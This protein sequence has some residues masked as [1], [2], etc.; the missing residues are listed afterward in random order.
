MINWVESYALKVGFLAVDRPK[1]NF[2]QSNWPF[3]YPFILKTPAR[4]MIYCSPKSPGRAKGS[5]CTWNLDYRV[6]DSVY[7]FLPKNSNLMHS[8]EIQPK[9]IMLDGRFEVTMMNQLTSSEMSFIKNQVLSRIGM[10]NLIIHLET[11]FP[12]R[13]YQ[14]ELIR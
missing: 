11:Q 5:K 12:S 2:T 10:P 7:V 1:G 4:G 8:H 3:N 6:K 14:Y 13:S 9:P